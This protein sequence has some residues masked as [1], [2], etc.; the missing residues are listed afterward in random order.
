MCVGC[1][2]SRLWTGILV[3]WEANARELQGL[4]QLQGE[5]K[6]SLGNL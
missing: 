3:T 2:D 1:Q 5:F 4:W 6:A